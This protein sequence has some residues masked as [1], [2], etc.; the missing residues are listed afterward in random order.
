MTTAVFLI[1]FDNV[2]PDANQPW[3]QRNAVLAADFV[4]RQSLAHAQQQ[5]GVDEVRLRYYGGWLL[6]RG[7]TSFD[8]RDLASWRVRLPRR[9]TTTGL[10]VLVEVASSL[11]AQPAREFKGTFRLPDRHAAPGCGNACPMHCSRKPQQKM[12]DMLLGLDLLTLASV[13]PA[14]VVLFTSDEDLF[15]AVVAAAHG[16]ARAASLTWLRPGR[17]GGDSPNDVLLAQ[18]QMRIRA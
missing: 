11:L 5:A 1:D 6:K 10:R 16:A 14:H 3:R 18:T 9:D 7:D 13:E 12:V 15:P 4:R 17:A 2:R 8:A